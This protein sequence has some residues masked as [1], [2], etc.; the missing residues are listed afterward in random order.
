MRRGFALV[1]RYRG[2]GAVRARA[3]IV[4][5]LD[6][7]DGRSAMRLSAISVQ[8]VK[9]FVAEMV[10]RVEGGELAPKRINNALTA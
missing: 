8:T 2:R 10:E 7:G 4:A 6:D 1:G 3:N 9:D 5:T